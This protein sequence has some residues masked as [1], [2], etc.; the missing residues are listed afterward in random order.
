MYIENIVL[1]IFKKVVIARLRESAIHP[2]SRK[3]PAPKYQPTNRKKRKGKIVEDYNR[4]RAAYA[5]KNV[6]A[7][8]L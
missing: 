5:N 4:D 8:L 6:L 3:T 7:L 2:I 1:L